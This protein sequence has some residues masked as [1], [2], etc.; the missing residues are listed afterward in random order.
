MSTTI[1]IGKY[2]FDGPYSLDSKDFIDRA[3]I[4]AILCLNTS[5]NK[6]TVVYIGE[7]GE[8]GTRLSNHNKKY[9]WRNHCATSLHVAIFYTPTNRYSME[10]RLRIESE[11]IDQYDPDCNKQ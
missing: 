6:Y 8:V 7:S 5:T 4:Y 9:C 2:S 1:T 10:D 11:L 3:A